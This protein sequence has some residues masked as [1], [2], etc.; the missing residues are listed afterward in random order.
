MWSNRIAPFAFV[1]L[2]AVFF[3]CAPTCVKTP[4]PPAG[5]LIA[6]V[7]S[8]P[9]AH[10]IQA[11]GTL[12]VTSPEGNY[13]GSAVVFYSYP[14][15]VKVVLQGGFGTT[16]AEIALAGGK[17]IAYL[18]QQ[19]QALELADGS[20]LLFGS[21]VVYPSMLLHLLK[22]VD[23][24][25]L[26]QDA[27]IST[28]CSQYV[29]AS[30]TAAG[31]RIWRLSAR[32]HRLEAEEFRSVE[33]TMFWTRTFGAANGIRVPKSFSVRLGE[34][35]MSAEFTRINV[36]PVMRPNTFAVALP[37]GIEVMTVPR[38]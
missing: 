24:E 25:R 14:E 13:S 2:G 4:P 1:F 31:T 8:V 16:F 18:P 12:R 28:E 11:Y 7:L 23:A 30:R 26:G 34:T 10:A 21:V 35:T 29:L 5:E 9:G 36:S 15:S 17:G 3:G 32:A 6:E 22:P 27:I 33:N 38:E 37:P 19:R 20:C